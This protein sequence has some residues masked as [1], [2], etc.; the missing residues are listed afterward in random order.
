MERVFNLKQLSRAA[1]MNESDYIHFIRLVNYGMKG[2]ID[3]KHA[4]RMIATIENES[5]T[6]IERLRKLST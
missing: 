6:L 5:K 3:K 1:G 2:T 4:K